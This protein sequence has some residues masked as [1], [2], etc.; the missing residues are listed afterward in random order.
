MGQNGLEAEGSA[1]SG[2]ES[3][4][5]AAEGAQE[6]RTISDPHTA[7]LCAGMGLLQW[8]EYFGF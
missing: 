7:A 4:W 1:F 8:L 3:R 5:G 6:V 2:E